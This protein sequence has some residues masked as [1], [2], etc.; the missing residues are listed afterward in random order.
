[1]NQL[2]MERFDSLVEGPESIQS[3]RR[4]IVNLAICDKLVEHDA[5]E[6]SSADLL[7]RITKLKLKLIADKQLRKSKPLPP[8][9]ADEIPDQFPECDTLVRL[10]DIAKIEKGETGIKKAIPG[11]FPLVVTAKARA[12]SDTFQFDRAAA[13]VPLV[14]STGHGHASINRLHYEEGKF[15]L[16]SILCAVVPLSSELVS[17][18]FIFEYL[19]AYKEELLVS[20]MLGTANVTLTVG[21][22]SAVPIP[23]IRPKNQAKVDELMALCDRL[24][25]AQ[26]ERNNQRNRLV[27]ATHH[28]INTPESDPKAVADFLFHQANFTQHTARPEHIKQLRQTI[29]NL[30]VRGKLVEQDP[31]DEP[32]DKLLKRIATEKER[33]VAEKKIKQP[34]VLPPI[35]ADQFPFEIPVGWRAARLG[36]VLLLMK[37]GLNAKPN[38]SGGDYLVTRIETISFE[39]ID[40]TRVGYISDVSDAD[41]KKH[42]IIKGD[43]L[44][45]HINSEIHMG[46]TAI[47]ETNKAN[48]LHGV[49]LL[50]LRAIELNCTYLNLC[51][52]D[53]RWSGYFMGISQRAVNQSSINQKNLS[54]SPVPIPPLAEQKRIVA[55]VDELMTL[56]DALE[57]QLTTSQTES[58]QLLEA[59]LNEAIA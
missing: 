36:D 21:K 14:S 50:L 5:S 56:C 54:L 15:A 8:I 35:E 43:I 4:F 48:L 24:E 29:L 57:V 26:A 49:N 11:P 32:A 51:L 20:K 59:C 2:L 18:R 6:E 58:Q 3:L 16:G 7:K 52:R 42:S 40:E 47:C 55:K 45:S 39:E 12:T 9:E 44:F 46:K 41:I 31:N 28:Q 10:S 30:A 23:V 37:N 53:L 34:K 27:A 19:T 1:M 38:K 25:A 22:I 13:I 17:A 33:L